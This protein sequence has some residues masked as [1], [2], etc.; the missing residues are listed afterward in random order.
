MR[1]RRD[2]IANRV[3]ESPFFGSMTDMFD[4]SND[5]AC[6]D[7]IVPVGFFP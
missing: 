3:N 2:V 1:D 5:I 7:V 4:I 6:F